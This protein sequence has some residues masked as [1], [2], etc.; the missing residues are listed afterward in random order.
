V[1]IVWETDRSKID[2]ELAADISELLG[3]SNFDWQ[4]YRGWASSKVQGELY[5]R[6]LGGGPLAAKPGHSAHECTD[7]S[8][9]PSALAVDVARVDSKGRL[10]WDY[11]EHPAWTWLWQACYE[12]PRLHSGHRFPLDTHGRVKS[13]DDH[14]QAVKWYTYKAKLVL[15]GK[16]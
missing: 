12:H 10:F 9:Y 8:G 6:Y 4:V 3:H 1:S 15:A 11:A 16:W 7:A 13:D 2:P 5:K 14:I